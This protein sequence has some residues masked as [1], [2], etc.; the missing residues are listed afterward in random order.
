VPGPVIVS[1][2]KSADRHVLSVLA[3]LVATGSAQICYIYIARGDSPASNGL[4][5]QF[6]TSALP[7]LALVFPSGRG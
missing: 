5:V 6:R 2:S 1:M 3:D 4:T 7:V